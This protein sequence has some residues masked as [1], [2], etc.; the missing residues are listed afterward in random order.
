MGGTV[1]SAFEIGKQ[2]V[3]AAPNVPNS[4]VEGSKFLLLPEGVDHNEAIF[5]GSPGV[6]RAVA[7]DDGWTAGHHLPTPPE[8]FLGREVDMYR[9]ISAC[10]SRRL[11][12]LLGGA[13]IGKSALAAAVCHYMVLRR[14]LPDGI[15]L[16][17]LRGVT[18]MEM[19]TRA[20]AVEVMRELGPG[21]ADK[22][23]SLGGLGVDWVPREEEWLFRRL[24]TQKILLVMDHIEEM[25]S[26]DNMG[27]KVFLRRLFDQTRAVKVL[28]TSSRPVDLHT[29]PGIGAGETLISVGPLSFRNTVRL[30]S[31]LC[32]HLHT[33]R[34][35]R[36]FLGKL[37]PAD[38]ADV[39]IASRWVRA[40]LRA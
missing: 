31:R 26:A 40:A 17:R 37:V 1:Q 21:Q 18:T 13:G 11:T 35:R 32:P 27:L 4:L 36:G 39:T 30:F 33:A 19:L 28:V 23:V 38:Q 7:V 25:Q 24:R 3:A 10:L 20:I 29:L 5:S 14:N 16:I 34:E 2:A 9:C 22:E 6:P 8:D 15:V 12:T